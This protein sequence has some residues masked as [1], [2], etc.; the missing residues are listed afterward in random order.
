MAAVALECTFVELDAAGEALGLTLR[1]FPFTFPH[2][3]NGINRAGLHA[4]VGASLAGRGLLRDNR[5]T[6]ELQDTVT[7]F[8]T[9]TPTIGLLG[10]N[11]DEQLTALG[12]FGVDR[13]LV[14]IRRGEGIRF[15]AVPRDL[16]VPRLVAQLPPMAGASG[17][18]PS[19]SPRL[20][21]GSFLVDG[22]SIGWVDAEEGRYLAITTRGIDGRPRIEYSPGDPE[23]V[24]RRLRSAISLG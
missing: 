6:P 5:F 1:R 18:A 8:G 22:R 16:V 9:G 21:G 13:G 17:R 20:G 14:A 19:A 10:M 12:V 3:G 11:G 15:D 23:T 4:Q 2:Y 24:E 7:L